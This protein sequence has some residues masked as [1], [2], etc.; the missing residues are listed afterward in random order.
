VQQERIW[1]N[2]LM[3]DDI[4]TSNMKMRT[5]LEAASALSSDDKLRNR[6]RVEPL[7]PTIVF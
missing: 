1:A 4:G 6:A 7:F 5:P 2:H 3:S